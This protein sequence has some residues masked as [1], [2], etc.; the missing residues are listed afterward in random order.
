MK[1]FLTLIAMLAIS[2]PVFAQKVSSVPLV[3]APLQSHLG[4][5][6]DSLLVK[7]H[8]V[9][10]SLP[11]PFPADKPISQEI[12]PCR[13]VDTSL[14]SAYTSPYGQPT[15]TTN[16]IRAYSVNSQRFP[17]TNPCYNRWPSGVVALKVEVAVSNNGNAVTVPGD[18]LFVERF[19]PVTYDPVSGLNVFLPYGNMLQNFADGLVMTDSGAFTIQFVGTGTDI[20]V[21]VLAY[22]LPDPGAQGPAGPAG[23]PGADGNPGPP[24]PPGNVGPKGDPGT[25]GTPGTPG[26]AGPKGDPGT[27]GTP[28]TP[29]PAGPKGDPGSPGTPGLPCLPSNPACVGPQGPPGPTGNCTCPLHCY[30]LCNKIVTSGGISSFTVNEREAEWATCNITLRGP[31]PLEVHYVKDGTPTIYNFYCGQKPAWQ[32]PDHTLTIDQGSTYCV[33]GM[34]DPSQ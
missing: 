21:D 28:G 5:T 15:F 33:L 22:F 8:L 19:S 31:D 24:G 2:F 13:M 4:E 11:F 32:C 27:P 30:N 14:S 6:D 9:K 23:P 7:T 10:S 26:P 3:V 12:V 34:P 25:P 18:V 17:L 16:E 20:T 29:G 1:K